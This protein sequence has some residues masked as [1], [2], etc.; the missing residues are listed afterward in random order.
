MSSGKWI[1][2]A[3]VASN[4]LGNIIMVLSEFRTRILIKIRHYKKLC[5][6][7]ELGWFSP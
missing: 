2:N 1:P 3:E 5:M 6:L 7:T 4:R